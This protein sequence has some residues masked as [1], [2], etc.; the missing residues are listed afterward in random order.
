MGMTKTSDLNS[1]TTS[2]EPL[3]EAQKG[4]SPQSPGGKKLDK[5]DIGPATPPAP[6]LPKK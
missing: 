3:K 1:D 2:N 6:H 5:D 4:T